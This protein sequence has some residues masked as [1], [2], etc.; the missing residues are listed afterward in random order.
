MVTAEVAAAAGQ[1]ALRSVALSVPLLPPVHPEA[2]ELRLGG[3]VI[4]T[5]LGVLGARDLLTSVTAAVTD[6]R[7][8][9]VSHVTLAQW[10][11]GGSRRALYLSG[12][13]GRSGASVLWCCCDSGTVCERGELLL[14]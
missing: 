6:S 2:T 7:L 3:A 11:L 9:Q 14:W 4:S 12:R 8:L 13:R 5:E 10:R 1:P